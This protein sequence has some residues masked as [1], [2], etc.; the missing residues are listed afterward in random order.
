MFKAKIAMQKRQPATRWHGLFKAKIAMQKR[1]PS[2]RWS[3]AK[4]A[5][6]CNQAAIVALVTM[7]KPR[8]GATR[9]FAVTKVSL[10][11]V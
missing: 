7:G 9:V 2:T 3:E 11:T 10:K 6:V 4:V 8:M 1:Q 5:V